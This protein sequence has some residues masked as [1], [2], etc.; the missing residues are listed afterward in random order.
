MKDIFYILDRITYEKSDR[1]EMWLRIMV[2]GGGGYLQ[3]FSC[4]KKINKLGFF[5]MLK[6]NQST[7]NIKKKKTL[8]NNLDKYGKTMISGLKFTIEAKYTEGMRQ[9]Q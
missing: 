8:T 3:C 7:N 5:K 9:V 4:R 1:C 2:L 6:Q